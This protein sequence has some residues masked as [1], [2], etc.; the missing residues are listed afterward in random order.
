[1]RLLIPGRLLAIPL[2]LLLLLSLLRQ[3]TVRGRRLPASHLRRRLIRH[4]L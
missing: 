3:P 1:M 2:L 4:P